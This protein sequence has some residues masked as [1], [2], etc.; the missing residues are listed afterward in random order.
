MA[1]SSNKHLRPLPDSAARFR[2]SLSASHSQSRD[3]EGAVPKIRLFRGLSASGLLYCR[4]YFVTVLLICRAASGESGADAWLRYAPA[5]EPLA[6]S[7]RQSL[8]AVLVSAGDSPVLASA[9][10]ELQRGI[11][12]MLSRR[13]RIEKTVGTEP[14]LVVGP[15]DD[16][17]K[18]LPANSLPRTVGKEGFVLKRVAGHIVIAG[19]DDRGTLYGV[20]AFLRKLGQ[21]EP[22]AALNETQVPYAAVRWMNH[23]DNLDGS[24]E[25]GYGGKSIFWDNNAV[26]ADLSRV[27]EYARLLASLGINGCSINNV[28]ANPNVLKPEMLEG[29]RRIADVMRPWGV[30]VVLSA[31]FGSPKRAGTLENFDPVRPD[32]QAWWKAKASEIYTYVPDLAG[33]VMK[34]DSEGRV[35]P[36]AYGRSH[37]DAANTVA[38][39]LKPH[40]GL[41][42]YR[43]FVYDHNLDWRNLKNDRARAAYDNFHPLDGKFDDNVVVQIKN[44]PIDFQVREPASPLFG[45]LERTNQAIELQITQEYFGQARHTVFLVPMW[46]DALDTDLQ[47]KG[48][49]TPVKALVAG[50]T[51][52]RPVGGFVGVSNVGMDDNWLGNHLS[53]ANL[54]GY[55]RLAW[56]PNLSARRISEEWTRLTFGADPKVATTV[57]ELQLSSWR[58]YENYTGPLGLQT[59]TAITGTHYGP[60]VEASE[61]NGWGQWHRSDEKGTGMDRTSATGTGYSGQYRAAVAK[62]FESLRECPDELLLF[63]HHVPYSHVL[64]SGK[65]V[66]QTLYDMHYEGASA[67]EAN[68]A[69]WKGLEG[70]VDER[71]YLEILRQLEYQAGAAELW[72]DAINSWFHKTSGFADGKGRVGKYANRIE[73]ESMELHGYSAKPIQPWE[74]ASGERIVECAAASCTASTVFQGKAGWYTVKVRYFDLPDAVSQFRAS[75]NGQ[76]VDWWAADDRFPARRT[77][78]S[79]STR[80]LIRGVALRPGDRIVVEGKPS[81]RETAALDYIEILAEAN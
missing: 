36:S 77:D 25:R 6:V 79:A 64:H 73:A 54:Y 62:R 15:L 56:D 52:N 30:R 22:L 80:R 58:M 2:I 50:K 27:R 59:L 38:R 37:A 41:M 76:P 78:S 71:R 10:D 72:R 67:A 14:A 42:F 69:R 24:I 13:L 19:A 74:S 46:K 17:A 31:D 1:L 23:W 75:V 12:G 18:M 65:T 3:R 70:R 47:A 44:G 20:F 57:N 48:P 8:P 61:R 34:A 60:S 45:A 16:V 40:G 35:G 81:G 32:V 39:A 51:F 49:G 5:T 33:F 11:R 66:I 28:N 26:R 29:V 21:G 9:R 7:Y 68:V 4:G 43:A 55:G 53:Q 63:L